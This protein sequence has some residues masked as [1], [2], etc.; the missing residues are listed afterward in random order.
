VNPVTNNGARASRGRA[1]SIP[2]DALPLA[3]Q[4][5]VVSAL[6][7]AFSWYVLL[8]VRGAFIATKTHSVL[9]DVVLAMLALVPLLLLR[10]VWH[11]ITQASRSSQATRSENLIDA[12]V[13]NAASRSA[14]WSA[15]GYSFAGLVLFTLMLFMVVNDLAVGRTFFNL[16]IILPKSWSGEAFTSSPLVLV[17]QAFLKNILI[18]TIAEVLIGDRHCPFDSG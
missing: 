4:A 11:G 14:S 15:M 10:F 16:G 18:F 1:P 12:R 3:L 8:Q 9:V 13:S 6:L 17:A 7:I 5:A 2:K